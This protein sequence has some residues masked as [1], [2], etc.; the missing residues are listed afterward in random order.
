MMRSGRACVQGS[1]PPEGRSAT[2]ERSIV[3]GCFRQLVA[4]NDESGN[5]HRAILLMETVK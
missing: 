1:R 2:V 3:G 5:Q 4:Y